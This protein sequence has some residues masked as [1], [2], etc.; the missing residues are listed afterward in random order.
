MLRP[1]QLDFSFT[2]SGAP[3]GPPSAR[4]P[5]Q[6]VTATQSPAEVPTDAVA[7]RRLSGR[8]GRLEARAREILCAV[9]GRRLASAVRVEWSGRMRSAAGR[10]NYR[11]KLITLN[12]RLAA[13]GEEEID[14]TLRHELAHLIAQLRA[15]GRRIAP[16]GEEWRMAC[17]E[18]GIGGEGRCHS[19][20]FPV[21]TIPPRF[22]YQCPNCGREFPRVHRIRRAI[23][24]LACCAQYS[25]RRYDERFRLRLANTIRP[26]NFRGSLLPTPQ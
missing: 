11:S 24:C 19:L 26:A 1:E 9:V 16:H 15:R 21:Q 20:P 6:L 18:I 14:R 8:D 22:A 4:S 10:A 7:R 17:L 13:H 5:Q 2:T 23:A 25:R 12:P 3:V